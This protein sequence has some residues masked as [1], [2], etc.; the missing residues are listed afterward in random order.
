MKVLYP[1]RRNVVKWTGI[2]IISKRNQT[3]TYLD[4][5]FVY[6]HTKSTLGPCY[7]SVFFEKLRFHC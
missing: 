5:K 7:T 3:R 4:H 1:H 6:I 2:V